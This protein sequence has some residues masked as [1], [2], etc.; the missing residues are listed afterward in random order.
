MDDTEVKS[1]EKTKA[2]SLMDN[3]SEFV[4][5]Y[6]KLGAVNATEKATVVATV[7]LTTAMLFVFIVFIL[8]FSGLGA[9]IWLGN[10]WNNITAG[11]FTVA[12]F[13]IFLA[14][15]FISLRKQ[16]IFP[17]LRNHIIKKIYE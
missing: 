17:Y 10:S 3:I 15:L 7:A 6:L 2:Q 1:T 13:Y 8:L 14:L 9:A 4:Q 5:I 12:G 16:M 11:Y